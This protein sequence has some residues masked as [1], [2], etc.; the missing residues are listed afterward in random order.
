MTT[1]ESELRDTDNEVQQRSLIVTAFPCRVAVYGREP[2]FLP[3]KGAP[4]SLP[5]LAFP[6]SETF[7]L[8][9]APGERARSQRQPR[10]R[11]L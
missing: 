11:C 4:S 2:I 7:P 9:S 5:F 1:T 8:P 3:S 10:G 6:P